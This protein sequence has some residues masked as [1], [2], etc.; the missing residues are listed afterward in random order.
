MTLEHQKI[1]LIKWIASLQDEAVVRQMFN[2]KREISPKQLPELVKPF[3]ARNMGKN[4][5][6][7]AATA[8]LITSDQDFD[9]L[10]DEVIKPERVALVD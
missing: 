3:S 1:G 7:I 4:D 6:W 10:A 9:H 8:A 5:I 2:F